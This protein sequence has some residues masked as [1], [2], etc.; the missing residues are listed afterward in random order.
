[1]TEDK[2]TRAKAALEWYKKYFT[3]IYGGYIPNLPHHDAIIEA[4][5]AMAADAPDINVSSIPEP[6]DN[7]QIT[8]VPDGYV[9]TP[10]ELLESWIDYSYMPDY[11]ADETYP[12]L[13]EN[14]RKLIA[15]T[16][17]VNTPL[18][19][20]KLPPMVE[21]ALRQYREEHCFDDSEYG[22]AIDAF[23]AAPQVNAEKVIATL[24]FCGERANVTKENAAFMRKV[25]ESCRAN[26]STQINAEGVD[27]EALKDECQ[28]NDINVC[29]DATDSYHSHR[30]QAINFCV[31]YI[32]DRYV[33]VKKV[34]I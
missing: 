4:L 30:C 19:Y 24:D 32:T 1:M 16:P 14:T 7:K 20:A 10:K 11:V 12:D 21:K 9:L 22:V 34:G 5:T 8:T 25:A 3:E 26:V 6:I 2:Q 13:R 29:S 28:R 27:L 31:N 23:F 33:L 18:A 17:Q 15:A